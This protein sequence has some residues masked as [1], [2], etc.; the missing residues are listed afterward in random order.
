MNVLDHEPAAWFLLEEDG[1]LFLDVYCTHG[2]VGCD[3]MIQLSP[4][5]AAVVR[6]QGRRGADELA[7]AIQHSAPIVVGSRSPYQN[8][9]VSAELNAR[10]LDAIRRWRVATE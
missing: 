4:E 5:E 9:A 8:R 10:S 7:R 6:E 1:A 2:P 3:F